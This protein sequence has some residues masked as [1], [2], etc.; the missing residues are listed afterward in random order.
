MKNKGPMGAP[1][2]EVPEEIT[3][4]LFQLNKELIST[5]NVTVLK[6]VVA[7]IEL[8]MKSNKNKLEVLLIALLYNFTISISY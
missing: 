2:D 8:E 7:K 6:K 3:G 4:N 1:E 5:L